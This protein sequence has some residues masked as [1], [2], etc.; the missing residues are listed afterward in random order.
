[1]MKIIINNINP[2]YAT[3]LAT[4]SDI[5]ELVAVVWGIR[6]SGSFKNTS[7]LF[8]T[9]ERGERPHRRHDSWRGGENL[10]LLRRKT[11]F[12]IR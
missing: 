7:K 5:V 12:S 9:R 4:S 10:E 6:S 11:S 1:M 2:E 8:R 3:L